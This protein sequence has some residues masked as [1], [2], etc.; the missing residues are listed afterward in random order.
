M[1]KL[2]LVP[3]LNTPHSLLLQR[4][5]RQLLTLQKFAGLRAFAPDLADIG[6]TTIDNLY[7]TAIERR[8]LEVTHAR[9]GW[10]RPPP[11]KIRRIKR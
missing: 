9:F 3:R 5:Q 11:M 8:Q 4:S 7:A 2:S 6:D 1:P 10:K